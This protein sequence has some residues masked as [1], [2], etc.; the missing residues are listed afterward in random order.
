[1]QSDASVGSDQ[2][3]S[4][5]GAAFAAYLALATTGR[6]GLWRIAVT[7]LV[8]IAAQILALFAVLALF[9]GSDTGGERFQLMAT[10]FSLALVPPAL[11]LSLRLLHGR[12][13]GDL[14]GLGRG[15]EIAPLAIGGLA[16]AALTACGL[17]LGVALGL[18]QVS[19][20]EDYQAPWLLLA[21]AAALIPA[22]AAGEELVFR[23]YL[24]Q[25]LGARWPSPII[26]AAL[27]SAVFALLHIG[28]EADALELAAYVASTFLFGLAAAA[29]V[30]RTAGLSAAIGLHVVNNWLALC[31][32]EPPQGVAGLGP[33]A[34]RFEPGGAPLS[35]AL[36]ILL[37]GAALAILWRLLPE[38]AAPS[39]SNQFS[40]PQTPEGG[41]D[42]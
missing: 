16:A 40:A 3:D 34:V 14:L 13:L 4:S 21:L 11:A 1:M 22:Q 18:V 29:L 10:L 39:I 36:D 35:L 19:V 26:W 41:A 42:A 7:I 15:L 20:I 37:L 23:G 38:P 30:W 2:Q 5:R 24:L 17:F 12:R 9:W 27:P 8:V 6:T 25:E 31:L 32:F 33:L 28:T